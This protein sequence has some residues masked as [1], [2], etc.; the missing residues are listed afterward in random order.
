[1]A[2]SNVSKQ[3]IDAPGTLSEIDKKN[4]EFETWNLWHGTVS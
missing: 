2:T 4:T 3:K 1:M